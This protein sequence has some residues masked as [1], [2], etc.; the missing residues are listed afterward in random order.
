M[1]LPEQCT[2]VAGDGRAVPLEGSA[3]PLWDE[4]GVVHG[5]VITLR[6]ATA[7]R[8]IEEVRRRNEAYERQEQKMEAVGG[9]AGGFA[10]HFNNLLTVMLGNAS[11]AGA[12]LP[13]G[14]L[15]R[16][17]L[18]E[19]EHT[20]EQAADLVQQ[21]LILSGRR[22]L[23]REVANL[24]ELVM[25][26]LTG[27]KTALAPAIEVDFRP[28]TDLGLVQV[29]PLLMTRALRNL[30]LNARDAMPQGG[31]LLVET[32]NVTR[33]EPST[34]DWPSDYVMLRVTDDGRGIAPETQA[35]I[36]EPFFSTK[37][38]GQGTGL[39]LALVHGIIHEHGGWIECH[40]NVGQ[41]ARFQIYLP[42]FR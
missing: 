23:R 28:G 33:A 11:L 32:E 15:S 18:E 24:N 25:D 12:R 26:T 40:S 3:A 14:D 31:R 19:V 20:A 10:H 29:D 41:G 16:R 17:L 1:A 42:R 2:I 7:R 34:G 4:Q 8:Q 27:L 9:L 30:C 39:G 5:L 35:R 21:L 6:D 38:V 22:R 37:E 13:H 36:F